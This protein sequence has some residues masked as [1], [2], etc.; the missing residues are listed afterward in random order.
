MKWKPFLWVENKWWD[1]S[2][3]INFYSLLA[4]VLR[5]KYIYFI[6]LESTRNDKKTLNIENYSCWNGKFSARRIHRLK[7]FKIH[8]KCF[9]FYEVYKQ[10]E[11]VKN[12]AQLTCEW[13]NIMTVT[14][15][16]LIHIVNLPLKIIWWFYNS[17]SRKIRKMMANKC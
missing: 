9:S 4:F 16:Q 14:S 15:W 10:W 2:S 11:N 6:T 7:P 8:M 5:Y 3:E 17:F 1:H 12:C 13:F